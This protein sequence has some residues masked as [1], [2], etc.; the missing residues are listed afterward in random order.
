[1]E[2]FSLKMAYIITIEQEREI[3]LKNGNIIKILPFY[4]FIK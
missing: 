3:K 2:K 1:M 4:N